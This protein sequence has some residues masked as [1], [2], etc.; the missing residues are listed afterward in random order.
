MARIGVSIPV[1]ERVLYHHSRTFAGIVG[2]Y[3]RHDFAD[4]KRAAL[5]AWTKHIGEIV[6]IPAGLPASATAGLPAAELAQ[7]EEWRR[8]RGRLVFVPLWLVG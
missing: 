5:D 8:L 7:T 1:I 2:V 4:E 3:Q 6:A